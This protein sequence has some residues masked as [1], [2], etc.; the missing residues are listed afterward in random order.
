MECHKGFFVAQ[1]VPLFII[2]SVFWGQ[3]MVILPTNHQANLKDPVIF[4]PNWAMNKGPKRLFRVFWGMKYCP[5]MWGL[6]QTIIRIP[7]NQPVPGNVTRFWSLLSWC[8]RKFLLFNFKTWS[9]RTTSSARCSW[10]VGSGR[11]KAPRRGV[12]LGRSVRAS[13]KHVNLSSWIGR[14]WVGRGCCR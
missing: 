2:I 4:I 12:F 14:G 1:M 10:S 6:R 3:S 7:T 8:L 5:V 9:G 11:Q 13:W